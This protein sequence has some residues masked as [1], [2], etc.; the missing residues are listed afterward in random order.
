M[1]NH[2]TKEETKNIIHNGGRRE[3][4]GESVAKLF[5]TQPKN[6][7][8]GSTLIHA[9]GATMHIVHMIHQ[10]QLDIMEQELDDGS[11]INPF[12]YTQE[13]FNSLE[14]EITELLLKHFKLN[15]NEF[16][17]LYNDSIG[18]RKRKLTKEMTNTAYKS[19]SRLSS[20]KLLK[21][22]TTITKLNIT[23]NN[24]MISKFIE[25]YENGDILFEK[26]FNTFMIEYDKMKSNEDVNEI[27]EDMILFKS[28][29]EGKS[30]EEGSVSV[31]VTDDGK[32]D[33]DEESKRD[34]KYDNLEMEMIPLSNNVIRQT[35]NELEDDVLDDNG[36]SLIFMNVEKFDAAQFETTTGGRTDDMKDDQ[37]NSYGEWLNDET[38]NDL[39]DELLDQDEP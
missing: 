21:R 4:L 13:L 9:Q 36:D 3:L 15:H 22:L 23:K 1:H 27:D 19:T 2:L 26:K 14:K 6:V 8:I 20:R 17:V 18:L 25:Y 35:E 39:L 31:I 16:S 32:D 34:A 28:K 11:T 5:E 7:E 10:S 12:M 30:I 37:E 29:S 38:A 24:E 33:D